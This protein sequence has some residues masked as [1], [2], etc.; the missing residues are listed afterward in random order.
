IDDVDPAVV[1]IP[2][3]VQFPEL[4]ADPVRE[5]DDE[6]DLFRGEDVRRIPDDDLHVLL[7]Y[8][9]GIER[10]GTHANNGYAIADDRDADLFE[11][12]V[13]IEC[14]DEA[15]VDITRFRRLDR[16]VDERTRTGAIEV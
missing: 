3:D 1:A 2:K 14:I 6:G 11:V 10:L 7:L 5:S 9:R 15:L 4:N 8:L 16:T 13:L 12:S